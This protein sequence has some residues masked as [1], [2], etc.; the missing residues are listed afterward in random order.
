MRVNWGTGIAIFYSLFVI[1][2]VTA[3]IKASQLGVPLVQP[4]YYDADIQYES[5]RQKRSAAMGLA[6]PPRFE[7]DRKGNQLMVQFDEKAEIM[8]G[9]I[10][11]YRPSDSHSDRRS[12]LQT[13]QGNQSYIPMEGL[14]AGRWQIMLH[15]NQ[16]GQSMYWKE[17]IHI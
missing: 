14:K 1:I 11:F 15:W 2:M 16:D 5:F 17:D 10:Q 13:N 9:K 7:I 6:K 4:E 12:E 8:H 3:V